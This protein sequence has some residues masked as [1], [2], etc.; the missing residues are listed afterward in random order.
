M[1]RNFRFYFTL[2]VAKGIALVLKIAGRKGTSLPGWRALNMCPGFLGR[3]RHPKTVIGITGTNG[4]TTVSNMME[5]I[6]SDNG[7]DFMCNREGTNVESGII[8]TLLAHTTL[9]GKIK[10]DLAVFEIDERSAPKILPFLHVDILICTNLVRDAYDRNAHTDFMIDLLNRHI[11]DETRLVLNGDDLLCSSLKPENN[12]VFF[13]IAQQSGETPEQKNVVCDVQRCPACGGPLTWAFIRHH[14]IGRAACERCGFA[15]PDLTYWIDD[16]SA[17]G[18]LTVLE[19]GKPETYPM[20][21]ESE[22]NIY[23][24]LSAIST[25]REF[26]LTPA[27]IAGSLSKLKIAQTRYSEEQVGDKRVILHL[28]KGQSPIA[29]STAFENVKKYPGKKAVVLLLDDFFEAQHSV[30]HIA[31]LYETDFEY[32]ND[33]SICQIIAAGARHCDMQVRMLLADVPPDR[34]THLAAIEQAADLVKFKEVDAVFILHIVF[35]I[36]QAQQLKQQLIARMK[37][38]G[39]EAT[40]DEN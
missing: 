40:G 28:A 7:Y 16:R 18:P 31:W 10:K 20:V 15:S 33:D 22:M 13:G 36:E 8:S 27:Q 34:I 24:E 38:P 30:E 12:R 32:L 3:M 5:D 1:K 4:K 2:F 23:N 26:G 14:H 37:A 25:L 6:L 39:K 9:T 19:R 35:R 29:C 17:S 21:H 11:S